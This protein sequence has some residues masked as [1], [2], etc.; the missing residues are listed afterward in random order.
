MR[1]TMICPELAPFAKTGGLGDV[2]GALSATLQRAGHE[3]RVFMPLYSS[4]DREATGMT[5]VDF[6]QDIP[7]DTG[8]F[9]LFYSV[10]TA[11]LGEDGLWVYF[12]D[13]PM[14][15]GRQ[16]IYSSDPDE[17]LRFIALSRAALDCCQ[18]MAFAPDIVH[19]H[20]WQTALVPLYL[21]TIYSWD[22]LFASTRSV[23]SL[24]NLGY[25]GVFGSG[26]LP[27]TGLAAHA[28]RFWQ[29]DLAAGHINFL[30]TG[31]IYA[32]A[33]TTVSPTY[34]REICT[35]AYGAGMDALLRERHESLVGIL[36]GVDYT[37]WSPDTDKLIP[38][39][40]TPTDLSGKAK[41]KE[42]LQSRFQLDVD[43]RKPVVGIVSRLVHQKGFDLAY[44]VL[45]RLLGQNRLQLAV[46]GSGEY[47]NEE[48]FSWLE[49]QFPGRAAFYRGFSNALAHLV[50]AGSDM[51]LMPSLY[52][53]CGL[54]QMY[55]LRYGTIPIVRKTGGLA[56]TVT[57][58]HR[59]DG[60]GV[61]FE[62]YDS[63]AVGWA[64]DTALTLYQNPERWQRMMLN[65]MGRDYSWE[66]QGRYYTRLY[67][68]LH[69]V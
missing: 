35:P 59:N 53:P 30:K 44:E 50:E 68:V 61:V 34:A 9:G 29:E 17:H 57:P 13:C 51:F 32:D 48:F 1:I 7:L 54:N 58:H 56:D 41:N 21:K 4:I 45:P 10:Y 25:Q 23:L 6:L 36:N 49:H 62:N 19:C 2:T 37:E 64:L 63:A 11:P 5:P 69:N 47:K 43:P 28:H 42:A 66:R 16:G 46:V 40:Y 39:R 12:I 22:S 52:E 14:L 18:R 27:S 31:I 60:D 26:I 38:Y 8:G 67:E 65:G 20:D 24:H 3:L 15:Y 55:S 33:L